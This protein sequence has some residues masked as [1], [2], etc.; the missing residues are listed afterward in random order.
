MS[1]IYS[2]VDFSGYVMRMLDANHPD[3][4]DRPSIAVFIHQELEDGVYQ[5]AL[6]EECEGP[7]PNGSRIWV[8][9]EIA[10]HHDW[11]HSDLSYCGQH[12][13]EM[14]LQNDWVEGVTVEHFNI[15]EIIASQL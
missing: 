5:G 7:T 3:E 9:K 14:I 8:S 13:A 11:P 6:C 15:P 10:Q 12:L 1:N 4:Q 2:R